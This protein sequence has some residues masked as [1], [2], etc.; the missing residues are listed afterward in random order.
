MSLESSKSYFKWLRC[1]RKIYPNGCLILSNN[2]SV[3]RQYTRSLSFDNME[4]D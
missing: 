1:E 3:H 2:A 4:D